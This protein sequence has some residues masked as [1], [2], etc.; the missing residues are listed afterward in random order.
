MR[1]VVDANIRTHYYPAVIDTPSGEA[2][3]WPEMWPLE[4]WDDVRG[5]R[6]F[7][8]NM[9]NKPIAGD[10]GYWVDEDIEIDRTEYGNTILCID[11]A[12]TTAKRS[13]YTALAVIS[14]GVDKRLYV[15]HAEQVKM[16]SDA[17]KAKAIDLID[18]YGVGVSLI[19]TNQ[20]G[21]LWRQ[22]F[23][24]LP[25]RKRYLN[26]RAKKE[27]RIAQA[28]DFYKK[29]KVRHTKHFPSLE[30]Q[31]LAYP[32]VVHDDLVDAVA[33]GILYFGKSARA[34]TVAKNYTYTEVS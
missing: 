22:V 30:E 18:Q 12:V 10:Q 31:M 5:T 20:G 17:L 34:R 32:N 2:S 29:G 1:W 28:A 14:R 23:K 7:A 3:L 15:R 24:D 21:D 11:P 6:E 9:M 19:E 13:D 33:T 25:G 16:D 8:K 4:D 27:V 26:Q